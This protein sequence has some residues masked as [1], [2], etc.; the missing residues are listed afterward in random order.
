[1]TTLEEGLPRRTARKA[2]LEETEETKEK[3]EN[4]PT[5]EVIDFGI[6]GDSRLFRR[7]Q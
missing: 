7:E 2:T 1:M 4:G 6:T 5:E 3:S